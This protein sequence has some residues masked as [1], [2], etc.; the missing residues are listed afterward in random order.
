[1]RII[2]FDP[3]ETTGWAILEIKPNAESMQVRIIG[4]G[5][6]S[7][8]QEMYQY[9]LPPWSIFDQV[10]QVVIEDYII[11]PNR[12]T[13]H[14]GSRVYTAREIGRIE[15]AAFQFGPTKDGGSIALQ[16][17]STAKQRWPNKRMRK[18]LG[19]IPES[20]HKT[21]ALRHAFTWIERTFKKP[22]TLAG[23]MPDG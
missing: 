10:E 17:A 8:I 4:L 21:D 23:E 22:I 16:A 12:A 20:K 1:M 6:W 13:S 5:D 11:Y 19:I 15:F 14:T 9:V 7:G 3:G 18:Y 2:S